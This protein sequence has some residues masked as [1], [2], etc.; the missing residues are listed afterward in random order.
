MIREHEVSSNDCEAR[1][2]TG[3]NAQA[4]RAR[5]SLAA[6]ATRDDST[7]VLNESVAACL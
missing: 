3:I 6:A 1:D 5:L 7:I 4:F 2:N